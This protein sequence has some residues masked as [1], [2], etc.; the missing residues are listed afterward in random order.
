MVVVKQ[1]DIMRRSRLF[2]A[3]V[4]ILV[5]GLAVFAGGCFGT[6]NG[7]TA[8]EKTSTVKPDPVVES[9]VTTTSGTQGA[10]YA[11]LD[12]KVKN[13]GAEGTILVIASVTQDGKTV[14]EEMPVYLMKNVTHELKLTFPLVWKGGVWTSDVK[15]QIP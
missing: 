8:T 15:T 2:G 5:I 3:F 4:L 1:E 12:I 6:E 10:Y 7:G 14:Q 11:I 9:V 13:K